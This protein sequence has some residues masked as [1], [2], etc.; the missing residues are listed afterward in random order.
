MADNNNNKILNVPPLRFPEF[1]DEWEKCKVSDLLDF[2][3]TNSLSWEQLEYT[4]S[5][6]RN[7][8]YG[9][10]HVG[11]PTLVDVGNALL[12][13]IKERFV[14]KNYQLCNNGD[15]AFAD[16]S[17][18][19]NEVAKVVELTEIKDEK[20]VCGLHTIHGRD[21][22]G[23][24]VIGYKGYAFSS[25]AFHKQIRRIAQGTK[26]FS[27]STKN[28]SECYIGIPS[29]KEQTKIAAILSLLDRRIA[30]QTKIIEDLKKLKSALYHLIF[31]TI[32]NGFT[33]LGEI[34]SIVKGTQVNGTELL[35]EGDYYVMNG[36]IQPSGYYDKYNVP[37][38]T[39]SIS[40]GGNSCGYVQ[41]NT[42][43]FWSG[44]HCYTIQKIESSIITEF[45]YHYLKYKEPE[46]M[47]LRIGSGLPNIQ[48]KDLERFPIVN[49]PLQEQKGIVELFNMFETKEI[50]ESKILS[51]LQKQKSYLLGEMFI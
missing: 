5:G 50:N 35:D 19:T 34:A 47:K 44:G 42:L 6:M 30:V 12:P 32:D 10:I 48:K 3:S 33:S 20:V 45:L 28:F 1:T 11:L 2:Y 25:D 43:P 49:I 37:A 24:T 17:E 23:K 16:A 14:P 4:G 36:G 26:I 29:I 38:N 31:S 46:I 7:L 13:N 9:L 21:N 51:L 41:Y 8:H 40:E 39:I 27:I 18:D 15:V 22:K